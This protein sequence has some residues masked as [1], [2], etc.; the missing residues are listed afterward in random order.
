MATL[1]EQRA[2]RSLR[3][4]LRRAVLSAIPAA[5][6]AG[7]GDKCGPDQT[8][9]PKYDLDGGWQ[10]AWSVGSEHTAADCKPYC[11]PAWGDSTCRGG[12]LIGCK[13]TSATAM[14]CTYDYILC[15]PS[16]CGRLPAGIETAGLAEPIAAAAWLEG[17]AVYAF[18]ALERELVAHGAPVGLIAR[19]RRAQADEKRHHRA[20]SALAARFGAAVPPVQV[21]PI[22]VRPL[23]E[24]ALENAVE[25]CV[26]ETWGAAVAAF[27]GEQAEDR[28]VRRTMRA[29]ARDEAHHAAL[30]W[31]VDA[32]ARAKLPPAQ[33]AALDGART[34]ASRH[35]DAPT[36]SSLL[37]LPGPEA[38]ATMLAA[39]RPLWVA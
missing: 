13:L 18:E 19:A 7:C 26:R 34:E 25:G 23:I 4:W 38:S 12:E 37:G 22:G 39:L 10:P 35:I 24:V 28:A 15:V 14:S 11:Y 29:I 33:R 8:L 2:A 27:Q 32:W 31:D 16:P 3:R 17:A 36:S 30:G 6:L 5:A 1:Q 20:M 21:E 9:G